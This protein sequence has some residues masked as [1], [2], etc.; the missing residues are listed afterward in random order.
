MPIFDVH[1]HFFPGAPSYYPPAMRE[2]EAL[3]ELQ[4]QHGIGRS[5]IYSPMT[6]SRALEAGQEPLE[7]ARGYNGFV[8]ELAASHPEEVVGVG[9]AFPFAGEASARVAEEA[10]CQLGL[11]GI[12]VNPWLDG[13]WLD[14]SSQAEPLLDAVAE[15]GVPLIVH[16]E[17]RFEGI[18]AQAVGRRLTHNQGLASVRTLATSLA[19]Y[20]IVCG[21]LLERYPTLP[22]IFAHGGG[23]FWG[24]LGRFHIVH[25]VL[26]P[27]GDVIAHGQQEGEEAAAL[28]QRLRRSNVSMDTAWVSAHQ[29]TLALELLGPERILFGSDAAPHPLSLPY[30]LEQ[31]QALEVSPSVREQLL[32]GNAARLFAPAP[33]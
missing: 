14:Q 6:I 17:E 20:G 12:M 22:L 9:I 23:G 2:V 13:Q 7:A 30:G 19:L 31:I 33:G 21:D 24:Q 3:L 25:N 1:T 4:R 28:L 32:W 26:L 18:L 29:L 11:R 5:A 16:P 10:V 27:Q 8:A 15:L